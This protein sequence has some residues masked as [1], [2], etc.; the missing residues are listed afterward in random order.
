MRK[1]NKLQLHA[2]ITYSATIGACEKGQQWI[3]AVT[4]LRE[5]QQRRMQA[6]VTIYNPTISACEK[7]QQCIKAVALL[8]ELQHGHM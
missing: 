8:R 5:M 3:E 4:L 1:P 7:G 6:N 2:V